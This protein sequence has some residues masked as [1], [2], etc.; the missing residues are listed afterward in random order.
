MYEKYY[1][2]DCEGPLTLNDNAFELAKYYINDGDKLFKILS[3]YDDYLVDVVKKANY[4]AGSTLKLIIPFFLSEGITNQDFIDFSRK[5]IFLVEGSKTLLDYVKNTMNTYIVST[6]Y[7]QY[8]EALSNYID[9][10]FENTFY[11]KVDI[12]SINITS[13]EILKIKEFKKDILK[14]PNDYDILNNVFFNE[15]PKMSFFD[16]INNINVIGGKGK[17]I[18]IEEIISKNSNDKEIFYI[19]DSITD[20]EPLKLVRK[21][22]GISISFNGNIYSLNV[23]EIAIVS[24]NAITTAII[25]NIFLEN[26]KKEVLNFIKE[27]NDSDNLEKLFNKFNIKLDLK[28]EFFNI[29]NNKDYPL[30]QIITDDNKDKILEKSSKMRN[31]IR[32]RDIGGLG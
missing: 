2:T 22:N 7:G 10:P 9:F 20:V 27:Y 17:Q 3:S 16:S 30:I 5:N 11:T 23:A 18:A 1:I 19:G 4:K 26:N 24:P 8:I 21:S 14:N 31:L 32:G 28:E 29:F 15:F 13:K 25:A 12:D 6:S